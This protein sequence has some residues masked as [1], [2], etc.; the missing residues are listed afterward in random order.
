MVGW[1]RGGGT[2]SKAMWR[3]EVVLAVHQGAAQRIKNVS[4]P[5]QGRTTWSR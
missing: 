5:W 3:E 1:G 4:Y 2:S